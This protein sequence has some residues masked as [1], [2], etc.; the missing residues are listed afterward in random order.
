MRGDKSGGGR[1]GRALFWGSAALV[2]VALTAFVL[3]GANRPADP[4]LRPA[5]RTPVSGFGEI[6]YRIRGGPADAASEAAKRC[7]LL[8]ETSEQHEQG[9]MGRTD[10]GGYDGMLFRFPAD[11]FTQF[12]MKDTLIPLSIAWFNAD[13]FFVSAADMEPCPVDVGCP[14]YAA[15]APYRYALEVAKGGLPG[16]GIGPGAQL[17]VEGGCT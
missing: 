3:L 13:G 6:G 11:T 2:V 5:G 12:Y 9:L 4:K 17:V 1:R 8:A 7:A 15:A 14:T 10:L 16:L